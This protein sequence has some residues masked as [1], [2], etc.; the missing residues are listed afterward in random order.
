MV[1]ALGWKL[2]TQEDFSD[3]ADSGDLPA[4]RPPQDRQLLSA[5]DAA[6]R[7]ARVDV[8]GDHHRQPQVRRHPAPV[9]DRAARD[10][11]AARHRRDRPSRSTSPTASPPT[12]GTPARRRPGSRSWCACRPS[13]SCASASRSSGTAIRRSPACTEG[14]RRRR[15]GVGAAVGRGRT[16]AAG[17]HP[18][19][20]LRRHARPALRRR[21]SRAPPA[22]AAAECTGNASTSP[23]APTRA[24]SR[25]ASSSLVRI[26]SAAS[27]SPARR[28]AAWMSRGTSPGSRPR[29]CASFSFTTTRSRVKARGHAGQR[30][31]LAVVAI[32]GLPEQRP[33]APRPACAGAR[34]RS[35]ARACRPGCA[36][37]RPGCARR[38]AR[39]RI[40]RPRLSLTFAPKRANTA[41]MTAGGDAE[42]G[43]RQR[44]AGEVGDVVGRAAV[45]GERHG[46]RRRRGRARARRG[47]SSRRP[48]RTPQVGPPRARCAR[49]AR[50][51]RHPGQT[52]R[53]AARGRSAARAAAPS[54]PAAR[55]RR[56]APA[57]PPAVSDAGDGELHVREPAPGRRCRTRRNDRR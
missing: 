19:A 34:R 18:A 50:V 13:S 40:M 38:R 35:A 3:H 9:G 57:G 47:C 42:R 10:R 53:A 49:S 43:G 8:G 37:S 55:R 1:T 33:E 32:A 29:R 14:A 54:P 25:T 48:S 16:G 30:L 26:G 12:H 45:D 51:R 44:R 27:G 20:R 39:K 11:G 15:R 56:S 23:G 2:L 52:S 41:A 4:A 17:A 28:S 22:R 24:R 7:G 5:H 36:R 31:D 46:A 21:A 6:H